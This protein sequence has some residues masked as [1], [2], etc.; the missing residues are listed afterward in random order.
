[1]IPQVPNLCGVFCFSYQFLVVIELFGTLTLPVAICLSYALSI[2]MIL[3]PP[4]TFQEGI[5]ILLL[6][7]SLVLPALLILFTTRQAS[8]VLWMLVYLLA[9]PIWNFVLPVYAFWHL[10][11]LS[12]GDTRRVEGETKHQQQQQQKVYSEDKTAVFDGTSVPLRRWADW[13]KS[14][15]RKL[16]REELRK[17]HLA[18]RAEQAQRQNQL[19]AMVVDPS[20]FIETRHSLAGPDEWVADKWGA[21]IGGVSPSPKSPISL[22]LPVN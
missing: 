5:P 8:Y 2:N 4:T 21:D 22:V 7:T 18:A 13:E 11:D 19:N 17:Q 15:L 3:N 6:V 10:D 9:L 12:W 14:R 16:R 1:M 20:R